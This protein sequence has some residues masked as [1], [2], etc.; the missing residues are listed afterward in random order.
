VPER[1]ERALGKV[2]RPVEFECDAPSHEML[3]SM[4]T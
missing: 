3:N 1:P 4:R 2:R